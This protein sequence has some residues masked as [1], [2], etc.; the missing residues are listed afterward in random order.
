MLGRINSIYREYPR[1][2][3][4]VVAASFIDRIGGTMLWPYFALYVTDK[5]AVGMTEAG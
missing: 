3:W 4:L 1:A 5:F 2:F